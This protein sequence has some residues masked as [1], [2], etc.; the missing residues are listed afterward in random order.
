MPKE[1]QDGGK[2]VSCWASD[3]KDEALVKRAA[4]VSWDNSE[5]LQRP[6]AQ[7]AWLSSK[8]GS[9]DLRRVMRPH[10]SSFRQAVPCRIKVA[11]G[12]PLTTLKL[13]F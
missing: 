13:F 5:V 3:P 4:G 1:R 8:A 6:L 12:L 2:D 9:S 7:P 10:L 11:Q